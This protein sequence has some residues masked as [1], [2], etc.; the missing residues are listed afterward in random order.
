MFYKISVGITSLNNTYVFSAYCVL[1]MGKM[2]TI[3]S[4]VSWS[5]KERL[6]VYKEQYNE[7]NF[8]LPL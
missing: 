5:E 6:R 7:S 8:K 4:R 1:S 3:K 2:N